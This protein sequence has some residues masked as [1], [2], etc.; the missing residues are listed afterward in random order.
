[1]RHPLF[2]RLRAAVLLVPAL[3]MAT[4]AQAQWA[5]LRGR[6]TDGTDAQPLAGA[7]VFL[8]GAAGERLGTATDA[9]GFFTL[10]G[11][12][13]GRYALTA[14]FLGY[15]PFTDTLTFTFAE[16]RTLDIRLTAD[17]AEMEEIVVE[18]ER[19]PD[20]RMAGLT[21]IAPSALARTP[22]PDVTYDLAGYLLTLPGFVAPG[23]RGGQLFVRGGTPT[24]NLVLLDG[25]PVYQ[26]FHIVG[27]FSAFPAD[28]LAHAD[29]YAGGF[30]ARYGGRISSVIDVTTR[31]GDKRRVVGAAS[32]APFLSSLRVEIP[33]VRNK[34]SVL[35]SVRESVIERLSGGLL[36][37]ELPF[38]FGDRFVKF[39]AFLSPTSSFAATALRTFDEGNV[40]GTEGDA[41]RRFSTWRN[42]A[43]GGRYTYLP[44]EAAV[45][46]Q[47]AVYVS[48]LESRYRLTAD[49]ERRADVDGFNAELT[50]RY[51]LGDAQLHFGIFGNT[52]RFHFERNGRPR[53][54]NANVTSG[55]GFFEGR[56]DLGRRLRLTPGLRLQSF[57]NGV[58]TALDPRLRARWLPRGPA[59]KTEV[60]IAWGL[61]HQQI[62]GLNNEQDVTDVF[63]V[64]AAAPERRPLPRA[65]HLIAGVRRRLL[66]WI[67]L[68][69]EGYF[70]RLKNVSFPRFSN[71][72]ADDVERFL[73]VKGEARGLDLRLEMNRPAFFARVSYSLGAV[74]YEPPAFDA[75]FPE[76]FSPPHDRRHQVNVLVA[77][78]R[79][80]Y[81]L[82][83]AWQFGS[84]LPFT[85]INGYYETLAL[86]DPDDDAFRT[87]SGETFVSRGPAYRGRLPAYHRL[88]VSARR[89]FT[90]ERVVVTLQA[91]VVN[92]Y[93]RANIF[94]YNF[95]TGER[96]NQLPL[97]PSAGLKVEMR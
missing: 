82:S 30:G 22:M 17:E 13:P 48:R 83:L 15:M 24:Q 18:S 19:R 49:D 59:S 29:V 73:R 71:A 32:I 91:G 20:R 2:R 4:A 96:V 94:Q 44:T 63:T 75:D 72:V 56:F 57:S 42:E 84:G 65:M 38:R 28:L 3:C 45:M 69:V 85:R 90:F 80:P 53:T 58:R 47:A 41:D 52:T 51:L 16:E 23:D 39:H 43:Y 67:E 25:M 93:D 60:T 88:D 1:M 37:R 86:A 27:F 89:V 70:K 21:T 62:I 87:R 66:P 78:A 11:I 50:F 6:V 9:G 26:P 95:F 33:V 54:G 8:T 31:N 36:G 35:A 7:G 92:A 55:G 74:T 81:R 61:Y 46:T 64:W 5:S 14:S 12:R 68:A 79:G 10:T 40:A 77:L 34:V 76:R 97:I